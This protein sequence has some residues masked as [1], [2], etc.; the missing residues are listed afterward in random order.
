MPRPTRADAH[1]NRVRLLAAARTRYRAD[2]RVPGLNELA[3]DVGMGVGTVYR[4]FPTQRALEEGLAVEPLLRLVAVVRD[5]AAVGDPGE[6]FER[7]VRGSVALQVR[8]VGLGEVV[9][10]QDAVDPDV[11]AAKAELRSL[12][13]AVLEAAQKAEAVR[14][15]V[16]PADVER[17]ARGV[18]VAVRLA[19]E[20]GRAAVLDAYLDVLLA[21]LRA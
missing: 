4:H 3:R 7:A 20:R 19:P 6:A 15:D 14:P 17:L 21:G 1:R 10:A 11:V 13:R 2:G 9:T 12:G 16:E 5:A 18:E 8:E